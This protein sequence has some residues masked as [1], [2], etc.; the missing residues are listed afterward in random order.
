M[1]GVA[2]SKPAIRGKTASVG[3]EYF[4]APYPRDMCSPGKSLKTFRDPAQQPSTAIWSSCPQC[5]G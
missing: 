3:I 1:G 5:A 2:G 4:A